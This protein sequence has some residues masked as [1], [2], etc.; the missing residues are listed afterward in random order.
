MP[1]G[2]CYDIVT[3]LSRA[4]LW[5]FFR[6]VYVIGEENIPVDQPALFTHSNMIVDPAVIACTLPHGR[7]VHMW[8]KDSLFRNKIL[9][10]II[11][12]GGVVPVDRTTKNNQLLFRST[13]EV[14]ALG[15]MVCVFPEGTSSTLPSMLEFKDGISWAALEYIKYLKEN[16]PQDI[17]S[18]YQ[19]KPAVIVPVCITYPQKSKYRSVVIITY[20]KPIKIDSYVEDFFKDPRPTVKRLTADVYAAVRR[21]GINA[22]NW[23]AWHAAD[24]SRQLLFSS[25]HAFDTHYLL[26][27]PE[28]FIPLTQS[29]IDFF[30]EMAPN[31]PEVAELQKLL[32]RYRNILMQLR[33]RDDHLYKAQRTGLEAKRV[34][35]Q[36]GLQALK[37]LA[38]F[39]LFAHALLVHLPVYILAKRAEQREIYEE[40]RAQDKI[41]T[42]LALL[43]LLYLVLGFI[44]WWWWWRPYALLGLAVASLTVAAMAWHH[45]A[46]LDDQYDAFTELVAGW[47]IF[48]AV[49]DKKEGGR[50]AKL[51]EA[52]RVRREGLEML[53]S[54]LEKY[55]DRCTA[56]KAVLVYVRGEQELNGDE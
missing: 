13:F 42:G 24:I 21:I 1:F 20:G 8:A 56:A 35:R 10:G 5:S 26:V 19:Y 32:L 41:F 2:V 33:I 34:S 36:T 11:R 53:E 14:L 4:S 44:I 12:N 50:A 49:M 54:C 38:Q 43:P 30:V 51:E 40:V 6:D 29:L 28:D 48:F 7:K 27:P 23:D 22:P 37:S 3:G 52:V 9:G 39:P 16:T 45:V 18:S 17:T 31:A 47:K 25:P 15:E 46:A 55:Q